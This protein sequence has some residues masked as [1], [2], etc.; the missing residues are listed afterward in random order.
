MWSFS[1]KTKGLFAWGIKPGDRA[2]NKIFCA[3]FLIFLFNM[4][5]SEIKFKVYNLRS[6]QF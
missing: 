2:L 1:L 6:L 3:C 4:S 5:D